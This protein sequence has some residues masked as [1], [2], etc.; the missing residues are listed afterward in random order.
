MTETIYYRIIDH[1]ELN[2]IEKANGLECSPKHWHQF[3]ANT[4]V[5]L[6]KSDSPIELA[7]RYAI[8]I[9]IELDEKI[10]EGLYVLEIKDPPGEIE[11]SIS[12]KEWPEA[13]A[14]IGRIPMSHIVRKWRIDLTKK[15][16]SYLFKSLIEI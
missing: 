10:D 9:S 4:I 13:V 3:Q 1:F 2:L 8:E 16:S 11:N 6:F 5:N 15:N 14:H 7:K 12:Q